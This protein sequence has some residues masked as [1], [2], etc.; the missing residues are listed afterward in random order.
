MSM[1]QLDPWKRVTARDVLEHDWWRVEPR[2]TDR[3]N[4]PKQGGGA[5]KMGED[6]AKR[7]GVVRDEGIF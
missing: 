2:P 6:I 5:E 3:E 7:Q 4:L 1:L